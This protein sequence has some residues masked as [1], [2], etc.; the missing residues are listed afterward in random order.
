MQRNSI[1]KVILVG[2]IGNKPEGRY[3]SSGTATAT[4]SLATNE[5]WK[6]SD[7]VRQ[8]KTEWHN[9]VAW[10]KLADFVSDYIQKGQLVYI[11]GKLQTRTWKDR[12]E[13]PRKTTEI[14]ASSI[15][16]LEWKNAA[17]DDESSKEDKG[18]IQE[19]EPNGD[20]LPF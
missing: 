4:F 11:E 5:S 12:D 18:E 3:L 6:G 13:N 8:D 2:H 16:P 14:V 17:A 1:N 9:I 7:Q 15:T 20:D 10:G 19:D